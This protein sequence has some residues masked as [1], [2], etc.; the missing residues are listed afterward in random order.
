[1]D[2]GSS[3]SLLTFSFFLFPFSPF[4]KGEM[5]KNHFFIKRLVLLGCV[6]STLNIDSK[7]PLTNLHMPIV[8]DGICITHTKVNV[9]TDS[10]PST[11]RAIF[12]Q[13]RFWNEAQNQLL[14]PNITNKS[15]P[16]PNQKSYRIESNL[17]P[18]L[19]T[20]FCLW[21]K[22]KWRFWDLVISWSPRLKMVL[23]V[24]NWDI[25][26]WKS[27]WAHSKT[28]SFSMSMTFG[29]PWLSEW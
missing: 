19:F 7:V 6:F 29:N 10:Q 25:V 2:G 1:M 22:W 12:F 8:T 14:L 15:S 9:M 26:W 20:V 3:F 11:P 17:S 21:L 16:L 13:S 24:P 18:P 27:F 28:F 5:S 4:F 23:K